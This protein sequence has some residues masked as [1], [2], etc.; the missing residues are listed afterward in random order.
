METYA[1]LGEARK[2]AAQRTDVHAIIE[3]EHATEGAC[4]ICARGPMARLRMALADQPMPE[5][6]RLISEHKPK[7]EAE[8]AA[9]RERHLRDD[10][11]CERCGARVDGSTAYSQ[12]E[13]S[14]WGEVTAWYCEACRQL[15]QAVGAGEYSAMDER[16]AAG[17]PVERETKADY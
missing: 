9:E 17:E 10:C 5:I 14:R 2:A 1:S 16:A 6:A 7:S 3:I 13:R 12:V 4:Y 8:Y 11:R 15:L